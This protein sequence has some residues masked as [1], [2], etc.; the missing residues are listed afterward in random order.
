M[1]QCIEGQSISPTCCE[2]SDIDV[3]IS[4]SFHLTPEQQSIFGWFSFLVIH[5]FDGYVLNLRI[6]LDQI[7]INLNLIRSSFKM[8]YNIE[9][10]TGLIWNWLVWI[11]NVSIVYVKKNLNLN[12]SNDICIHYNEK[13][14]IDRFLLIHVYQSYRFIQR[15]TRISL[16]IS[17]NNKRQAGH[18]L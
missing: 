7:I 5:F 10:Y 15:C 2:V 17:M 9:L 18:C 6:N 16:P 8:E 14:F 13:T 11:F 12:T 3:G 4:S 1:N